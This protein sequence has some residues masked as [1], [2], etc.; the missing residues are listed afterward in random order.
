M[1]RLGWAWIDTASYS[2]YVFSASVAAQALTVISLGGLANNR[3]C[4][5]QRTTV[6]CHRSFMEW[7]PL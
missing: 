2:L 6:P 1:V 3:T 7:W 4:S 5:I